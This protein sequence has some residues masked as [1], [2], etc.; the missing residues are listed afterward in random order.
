MLLQAVPDEIM[1][2]A[3]PV[4]LK[5]NARMWFNKLKP[6][7]IGDFKELSK[8]FVSYFIAGQKYCKPSTH[9]LTIIQ[10]RG[11]S[12]RDF[13]TRFNKEDIQV[14]SVDDK[15]TINA[16]IVGLWSGQFLFNLTQDPPQTMAELMLRAQKHMNAEETLSARRSR[17]VQEVGGTSQAS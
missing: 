7:S 17:A 3:F 2:R 4:T 5:G 1:C 15:V 12:L 11:E 14:E 9:L 8:S 10:N 16:C 6:N 13:M